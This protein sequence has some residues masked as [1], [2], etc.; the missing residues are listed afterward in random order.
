MER[1]GTQ[2]G[3]SEYDIAGFRENEFNFMGNNFLTKSENYRT[4][5]EG[6]FMGFG[7]WT[8][9]NKVINKKIESTDNITKITPSESK[10]EEMYFNTPLTQSSLEKG[11][12]KGKMISNKLNVS[13]KAALAVGFELGFSIEIL[14]INQG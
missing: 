5:A 6:N 11:G 10:K 9:V 12:S 3:T 8:S 2:V 7:I 14:I 13:V 4:F 1:F